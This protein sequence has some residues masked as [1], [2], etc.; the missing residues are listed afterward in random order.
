MK[1]TILSG[2]CL[3]ALQNF[4]FAITMSTTNTSNKW[5]NIADK[6]ISVGVVIAISLVLVFGTKA[7]IDTFRKKSNEV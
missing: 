5:T 6:I 4:A 7:I 2:A 3:I 1:K